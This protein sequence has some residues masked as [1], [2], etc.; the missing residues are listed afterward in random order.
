ME[1]F[2]KSLITRISGMYIIN[3]Q[4]NSIFLGIRNTKIW[5]V[6]LLFTVNGI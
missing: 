6:S 3:Q 5:N 4:H 1:Q 2:L